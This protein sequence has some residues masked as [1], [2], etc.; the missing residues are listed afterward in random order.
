[1]RFSE[2]IEKLASSRAVESAWRHSRHALLR[3]RPGLRLDVDALVK[4]IDAP[5]FEEIRQRHAI[6]NPGQAWPKYLNLPNWM[7]ENLRRVRELKLELGFRKRVLDLG[8]GAGYFLHICQ[9]LGHDV[10]G[11]DIDEVSMYGE[12]MMVL[13]LTRVIWRVEPFVPLPQFQRKFDLIAAFM[14]CFNGHKSPELWGP[15]EWTFF[16]DDLGTRLRRGGRI[17]LGFNH[18]EDGSFYSEELR[19][20]FASRGAEMHGKRVLLRPGRP[21]RAARSR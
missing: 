11:L 20:L 14:I 2:K 3:R 13:G 10:I 8:C 12:M 4:T 18:E 9:M 21:F 15:K 6:E 7:K 1:M 19:E 17:R 16:L 5:R